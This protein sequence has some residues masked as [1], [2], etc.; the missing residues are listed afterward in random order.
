M[1]PYAICLGTSQGTY[2]PACAMITAIPSDLIR[3]RFANR[4]CTKK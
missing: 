3:A 1:L 2:S 4:V